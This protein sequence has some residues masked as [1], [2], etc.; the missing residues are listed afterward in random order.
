[1]LGGQLGLTA[2]IL[3]YSRLQSSGFA[4]FPLNKAGASGVGKMGAAFLGFYMLG[5]GYV[6]NKFGDKS[7][8]NYLYWNKSSIINGSKTWE[9]EA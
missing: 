9:Q 4:L 1:M 7:Q 8:F 5:H 6:M 3:T 2:A